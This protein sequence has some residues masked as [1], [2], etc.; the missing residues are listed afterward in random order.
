M[1]GL[2]VNVISAPTACVGSTEYLAETLSMEVADFQLRPYTYAKWSDGFLYHS[3]RK[4]KEGTER[5]GHKEKREDNREKEM[6]VFTNSA[7]GYT[8]RAI[9][10]YTTWSHNNCLEIMSHAELGHLSIL[11]IIN[12]K[13]VVVYSYIMKDFHS[14]PKEVLS[15]SFYN[16]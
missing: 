13:E 11:R 10:L 2:K 5:E 1:V 16:G 15:L 8:K 7:I 4:A 12:I 6:R 14:T 9:Q 3:H